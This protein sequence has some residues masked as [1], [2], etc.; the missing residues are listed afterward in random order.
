MP[1]VCILDKLPIWF[2]IDARES[3]GENTNITCILYPIYRHL[4]PIIMNDNDIN[5]DAVPEL[6][7]ISDMERALTDIGF[8]D[9]L[10]RNRIMAEG[11]QEL[12]EMKNVSSKDLQRMAEDFGRRTVGDGR[13]IFGMAR[14]KKVVGLML[15]VKDAYR[16]NDT[17]TIDDLNEDAIDVAIQR[18]LIRREE[19]ANYEPIFTKALPAKLKDEKDWPTFYSSLMNALRII[20]G[21]NGVPLIYLC[22]VQEI[23]EAGVIYPDYT[24][25]AIACAPLYGPIFEADARRLHQIIQSLLQGEPAEAWI[26][27]LNKFQDGRRDVEALVKHFAGEGNSTRRLADAER[28]KESLHYKSERALPYASFLDELVKMFNIYAEEGESITETGKTRM[29]LQKVQNSGLNP[30]VAALTVQHN[31]GAITFVT[32]ANHLASAVA[33]L[34]E[35]QQAVQ[36]AAVDSKNGDE[37]GSGQDDYENG[38]ESGSGQ[39]DYE[40]GSEV[41]TGY[42]TK[43]QWDELSH[44]QIDAIRQARENERFSSDNHEDLENEGSS[45]GKRDSSDNKESSDGKRDSSAIT[46][47]SDEDLQRIIKAV[48]YEMK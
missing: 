12:R 6:I 22:R 31:L 3:A 27:T 32:A 46:N 7:Q 26:K 36:I 15:W 11:F 21:A 28:L 10:Q 25:R 45:N 23:P 34:P 47:I 40:S 5:N 17:P 14:T 9:P 42:Y 8:D 37:S 30:I 33:T 35:N 19:K 16:C 2:L 43:E 29:L 4:L 18:D 24:A 39:N 1:V 38:D 48:C 13:V 44:D 41:Y 20:P